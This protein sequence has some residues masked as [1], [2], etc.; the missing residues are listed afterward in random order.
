MRFFFA[1]FPFYYRGGASGHGTRRRHGTRRWRLS[2]LVKLGYALV[3][4]KQ[5]SH[6][7]DEGGQVV[8]AVALVAG[9]GAAVAVV[10]PWGDQVHLA[11]GASIEHLPAGFPK[12]REAILEQ[13][14]KGEA[15]HL[16]HIHYIFLALA[17][18]G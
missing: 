1:P 17:D 9:N 8:E 12:R 5:G 11:A 16:Y 6:C 3:I 10:G 7:A 18:A 4:L 13:L 2:C 15:C 14:D